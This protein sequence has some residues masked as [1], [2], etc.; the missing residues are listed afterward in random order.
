MI[1]ELGGAEL[2]EYR[3]LL[4]AGARGEPDAGPVGGVR[5]GRPLLYPIPLA[6]LPGP[7]RHR[8]ESGGDRYQGALFA[9][10]LDPLPRGRRY[11]SARFEVTLADPES[12]AVRVDADGDA[13]GVTY[14]GDPAATAAAYTI[15]AARQRPGWLRRLTGRERAPRAWVTGV[16][17]TRFGWIYDDPDGDLLLP[18]NYGMH[19]V[20]AVPEGAT[21]VAGTIGVQVEVAAGRRRTIS[22]REDL[23]FA[24][25]VSPTVPSGR[26]AVRLC[27]AADVA[28]YSRRGNAAAERVQQEIVALLSRVRRAAGIPDGAVRPQPQGDGQFTVLPVGIDESV[29]IPRMLGELYRA[30][31]ELNS[32]NGDRLRMRVALHRGLL[33]EGANGWVGTASIAVHRILDSPPMRAALTAH[34]Q[35]DFVLG[36]PDVLYRDVVV[37]AAEPPL[38]DQFTAMTVDLPDKGFVEHAWLYVG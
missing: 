33:L 26:A 27:V 20:L 35:A 10:D 19:A 9:F 30:L 29:V 2:L 28:G 37:P 16:Q 8:A 18:R 15:D 32:A 4:P 23:G 38:P 25:P 13:L 5:C 17:S 11:V 31:R 34:P 36:V 14:E 24:E 3:E 21:R 6:A 22:L 7:L 12:I 1:E